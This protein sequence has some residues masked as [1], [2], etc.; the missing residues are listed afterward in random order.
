MTLSSFEELLDA[1]RH[2]PQPQ[3][4]LFAFATVELPENSTPEQR[5]RFHMGMGG[6][7]VPLM[8]VD[9]RPEELTSFADLANDANQLSREWRIVFA[10]ALS[11]SSGNAPSSEA[12]EAHL[13]RMVAAIKRGE[14]GSY[15][16]FDQNGL[17]VLF[18]E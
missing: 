13:Q 18:D 14:H 15:M 11:G 5:E 16:P 8:C 6:A 17:P 2:Q 12:A 7:L 1:A 4:L 3:R 9:K 10:A